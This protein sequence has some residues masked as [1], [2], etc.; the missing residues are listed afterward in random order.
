MNIGYRKRDVR[1]CKQTKKS[2]IIYRSFHF[3]FHTVG[4]ITVGFSHATRITG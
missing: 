1:L 2:N 3:L 4:F